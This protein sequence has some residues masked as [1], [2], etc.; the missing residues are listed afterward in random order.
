MQSIPKVLA[1]ICMSSLSSDI[2]FRQ[3]HELKSGSQIQ[4]EAENAFK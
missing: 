4:Y 1:N 3:N 2:R